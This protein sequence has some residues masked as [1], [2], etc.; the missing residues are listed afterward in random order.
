VLPGVGADSAKG[1]REFAAQP[2]VLVGEFA[3]AAVGDFE[4]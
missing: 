4:A 2:P 3:V 1:A